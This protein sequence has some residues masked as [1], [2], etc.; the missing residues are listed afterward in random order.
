MCFRCANRK[1]WATDKSINIITMK[2]VG[3]KA[4]CA[5]GDVVAISKSGLGTLGDNGSMSRDFFKE[6]YIAD[7]AL[8]SGM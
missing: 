7:F 6:E 5:G 2:G 1:T 8:G 3:G 4:F